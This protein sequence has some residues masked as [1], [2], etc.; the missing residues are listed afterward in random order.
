M[1]GTLLVTPEKLQETAS[2]MGAKAAQVQALH[3]QMIAKVNA[4]NWE[5]EAATAYKTK[6][7]AL[8]SGMSKINAMIQEHVRDLNEMATTYSAAERTAQSAADSLPPS[9]L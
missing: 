7:Q 3:E 4:L 9:T 1:E 6:F 2:A 8:E 5:G